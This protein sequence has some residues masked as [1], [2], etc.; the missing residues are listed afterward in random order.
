MKKGPDLRKQARAL[1]FF[2][3]LPLRVVCRYVIR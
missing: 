3:H 1:F 2:D